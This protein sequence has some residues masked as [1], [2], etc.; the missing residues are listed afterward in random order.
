MSSKDQCS[1]HPCIVFAPFQ[2]NTR[3]RPGFRSRSFFIFIGPNVTPLASTCLTSYIVDM[4]FARTFGPSDIRKLHVECD[5]SARAIESTPPAASPPQLDDESQRLL[6][7]IARII[8]QGAKLDEIRRVIDECRTFY[9]SQPGN[10]YTPVRVGCLLLHNLAEA[11][12]KLHSQTDQL[13]EVAAARD[14]VRERLTSELEAMQFKYQEL[15]RTSRDEKETALAIE[16]SLREHYDQMN[17]FWKGQLESANGECRSLREELDRVRS[18]QA[19]PALPRP[20]PRP[21]EL[22]YF[23]KTDTKRSYT[24]DPS[25]VEN[26]K[27][28]VLDDGV[29]IQL[30]PLAET[31]L[32]LPSTVPSLRPLVDDSD[33]DDLAKPRRKEGPIYEE[34]EPEPEMEAS[35]SAKPV[36]F[37]FPPQ[38]QP[39]PDKADPI[40]I[41]QRTSLSRRSSSMAMSVTADPW[42]SGISG[43]KPRDDVVMG[44]PP[45]RYS[46]DR[47]TLPYGPRTQDSCAREMT[48][49]RRRESAEMA[50]KEQQATL[51]ILASGVTKLRDLLDKPT[52]PRPTSRLTTPSR[53]SSTAYHPGP[54]S[55]SFAQHTDDPYSVPT[56]RKPL[57][58]AS[59][60][61]MQLEKEKLEK[62]RRR[63]R[64]THHVSSSLKDATNV[65]MDSYYL[66]RH[67]PH[68]AG[69]M[70]AVY[71]APAETYA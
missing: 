58:S 31:G 50:S 45:R 55:T 69:K 1:K 7:D 66:H 42:S 18:S 68:G 59:D 26:L 44:S 70:R 46:A 61:A 27:G 40:S 51:E 21:V 30:S 39:R 20:P 56:D 49:L 34:P 52:L 37:P 43:S 35:S 28:K 15:Q 57:V 25:K 4:S 19:A 10:Q 67:K 8:K 2:A 38:L 9:K 41:P 16:R 3:T 13:R 14:E 62:E 5:P 32:P 65:P 36:A 64:E 23:Y 54:S 29:D 12:R 47:P 63:L 60:V 71:P 11:H 6:D 22:Q 33:E 48:E 24:E 53:P 17:N